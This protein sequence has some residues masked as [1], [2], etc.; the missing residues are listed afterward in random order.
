MFTC[1][2][3]YNVCAWE[4]NS[5]INRSGVA[6]AN[7]IRSRASKDVRSKYFYFSQ[8]CSLHYSQRRVPI[9]VYLDRYKIKWVRKLFLASVQISS[10]CGIE[11][12]RV[13]V[14]VC[15]YIRARSADDDQWHHSL[16]YLSF[17]R[18]WKE[19]FFHIRYRSEIKHLSE[20]NHLGDFNNREFNVDEVFIAPMCT[21]SSS[22]HCENWKMKQGRNRCLSNSWFRWK[23]CFALAL[24]LYFHNLRGCRIN[25]TK[26]C[27]SNLSDREFS[28][29]KRLRAPAYIA[30]AKTH[31]IKISIV[32]RI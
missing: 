29:G 5:W 10:Q 32:L 1:A 31:A 16:L 11:S 19:L 25:Q 9:F 14:C 24:V 20:W 6:L 28:F 22:E 17:P 30:N 13:C 15:V 3:F 12:T 2:I 21:K 26:I 27:D 7:C 4:S 23:I 18:K 8:S